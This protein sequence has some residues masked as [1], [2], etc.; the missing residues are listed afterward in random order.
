L[1]NEFNNLFDKAGIR[2]SDIAQ[3]GVW[4]RCNCRQRNTACYRYPGV[5]LGWRISMR[6]FKWLE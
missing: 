5:L 1:H 4:A 2:R 6:H 3:H